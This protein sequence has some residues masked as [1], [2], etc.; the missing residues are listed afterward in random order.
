MNQAAS[1]HNED[2]SLNAE[3]HRQVME[4]LKLAGKSNNRAIQQAAIKIAQNRGSRPSA[5]LIMVLGTVVVVAAVPAGWYALVHYPG[6]LGWE[7]TAVVFSAVL[8]IIALYALLS[9]NLSQ[10]NFLQIIEMVWAR[11]RNSAPCSPSKDIASLHAQE[12]VGTED[13]TN[14]SSS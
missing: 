13:G 10:T 1:A 11:F 3:A 6:T 14:D 7:I 4:L 2:E 8:I 9:G 12:T 5:T